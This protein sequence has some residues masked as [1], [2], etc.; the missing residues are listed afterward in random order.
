M[1]A[2]M[3]KRW[4]GALALAVSAAL[5]CGCGKREQAG[6]PAGENAPETGARASDCVTL[7]QY[8]GLKINLAPLKE[9]DDSEIEL[10]TKMLYFD[11]VAESEGITDRPVE[12]LDMV[13]IDYEG[14]K[15]GVAFD[16][17][18]AQGALLLIGSGQFIDGFEEGLIGV[19]PG[20]TVDLNLTFPEYYDSAELA[21]Q[22]V[23]FTVTVNFIPQMKDEK[24]ASLGVE[25]VETVDT[26]REYVRGVL[27]LQARNDYLATVE[28]IVLGQ[29]IAN[30]TFG[31]LP[32]DM[33]A[34]NRATYAQWLDRMAGTY[35]MDGETYLAMNG[36]DYESTLDSYAEQYTKQFVT[37]QAIA[38]KENLNLSDE[39]LDARL[40]A[41]AKTAGVTV[42]TLL[43]DNLTKED[44]RESFLYEDVL[45]YLVDNA[46][47]TAE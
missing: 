40:E 26:L 8:K 9:Y 39:S 23:V 17:G 19:T 45:Y 13:N 28:E 36:L 6:N 33:V 15:D 41:Y 42:D 47:N 10:Q 31:E 43:A 4:I 22:E 12:L 14:K 44:F 16:G 32:E 37:V 35:G 11:R 24:V 1:K 29:V 18:T 2:S 27:N 46:E 5:L 7:G 3:R 21:G 38:D 20:E 30:S 25:N 34:E